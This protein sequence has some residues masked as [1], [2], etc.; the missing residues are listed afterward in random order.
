LGAYSAVD[1][2]NL[3]V[4]LSATPTPTITPTFTPTSTRTPTPTATPTRTPTA[5]RTRTGTPSS[6]PTNTPTGTPTHT[7]SPTATSTPSLTATL[8]A[9]PTETAT[10]TPSQTP[11]P[12]PTMTE[13]PAAGIVQGRVILER[14]ASN[15]GAEVE[16]AGR[17][18][19]TNADGDYALTQ[20]PAGT[21]NITSRHQSYLRTWRSADVPAGQ[22]LALPDLTLLAG[23]LD[24]DDHIEQADAELISEAWNSTSDAPNWDE[25]ADITD[26]GAVN[27]LDMVA[28]QFNWDQRAPGPWPA[29]VTEH[30]AGQRSEHA[31]GQEGAG[32]AASGDAGSTRLEVTS[33]SP[34]ATV[35]NF[36]ESIP[37]PDTVRSQYCN[38]P[39]T[40]K[41]VQFLGDG[42]RIIVPSVQTSSS[43]K[44]LTNHFIGDEF[45]GMARTLDIRFTTGQSA[46][47]VNVGLDQQYPQGVIARLSAYSSTTPGEGF[48]TLDNQQL[49]VGP[50]GVLT[51]LAVT[52]EA[53][54]IRS[55]RI[56]FVG[57]SPGAFEVI[58]DL[59]FSS[60]GPP[61]ITDS[62]PPT[63][64]I[65]KPS[66]NGF[67][68][69]STHI[70]L[71]FNA[72]DNGT[73]VSRIQVEFYDA[74]TKKLGT[75]TLCGGPTWSP[76]AQPSDSSHPLSYD[77]TA[78]MPAGTSFIVAKAWDFA[79]NMGQAA[80][81]INFISLGPNVNLWAKS[82]EITQGT[83]SWLPVNT[84][85]RQSGSAP[86]PFRYPSAPTAVP[87]VANRTTVVRLYGGVE[88]IVPGVAEVDGVRASLRC[89]TD[90]S[91]STPCPGPASIRPMHKPPEF[92]AEIT[93]RPNDTLD[94]KQRNSPFSWNFFL[95]DQWIK[96]GTVFLE[97]VVAP[98]LGVSECT[99]CSDAANRIRI[100]NVTFNAVPDYTDKLVYQVLMKRWISGK[101]FK[102][103]TTNEL[104]NG[105]NY[106]RRTYPVDESTV[107]GV[108]R[109]WTFFDFNT[110]LGKSVGCSEVLDKMEKS[111]SDKKGR[112]VV[113]LVTDSEAPYLCSGLGRSN[114]YTTSRGNVADSPAHEIGH[115]VGLLHAGPPPGHA[116]ECSDSDWCD[117]DWPY[118]H[119]TIGAYGFDI[120]S[121]KVVP[122]DQL[123]CRTPGVC[124]NDKDDDGDGHK[125]EE[126]PGQVDGDPPADFANF[127]HDFMSYGP[128]GTWVSPRNWIRMFNAFT[129][130]SLSYP[131]KSS[132]ASAEAV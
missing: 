121:K 90:S 39:T 96:Q 79:N 46:V 107:I 117:G 89:F 118:S 106:I 2:Y 23:D 124:D 20:I 64:Q 32:I 97:G 55:V 73:G 1:P 82:L 98:P 43:P 132:P 122:K 105:L 11:S 8:T 86:V 36:E 130:S 76:C 104:K 58:D 27:I 84:Q 51:T 28:V 17:I 111:F 61:C 19:S 10:S 6:T 115:G 31:P 53:A 47:S 49:G 112:K 15:A 102:E 50:H 88:G 68:V 38:N 4:T 24:Q 66:T 62:T 125:D 40:N 101:G 92:F 81:G 22:T 127:P 100:S 83:Q 70:D 99:G 80:R 34:H 29:T 52:S 128:C 14:R 103:P 60:V 44:A 110:I 87:L 74:S 75:S 37:F 120:L 33:S 12:T 85:S 16:A 3:F 57:P 18:A 93:V 94:M 30:P 54:N 91:Y 95:P 69:H 13:T 26:D 5:T 35:I 72:S 77:Y 129:G 78:V 21:H 56:E 126:C 65:T 116:A 7:A 25:R 109:V 59:T 114:G 113:A 45:A 42:G 63:V 131:K 41:G 119:G 48:V 108:F 67:V 71:R 9:T 123:E